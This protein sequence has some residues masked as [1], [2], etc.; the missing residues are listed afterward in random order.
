M[1]APIANDDIESLRRYHSGP[2]PID[3]RGYLTRPYRIYTY[4]QF[5]R[6]RW[7]RTLGTVYAM[8]VAEARNLV[9]KMSRYEKRWRGTNVFVEGK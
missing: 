4:R 1:Q 3:H 8:H 9:Q 2:V 7:K 6:F 5:W